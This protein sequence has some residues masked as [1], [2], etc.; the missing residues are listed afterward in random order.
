M[1]VLLDTS[2]LSNANA[3]RG[4]GTYT[5]FLLSRLLAKKNQSLELYQS[6]TLS[7]KEL[8]KIKADIVHYPYFDFFFPTLPLKLNTKTV[9]TIHDVI[10]LV[11]P[12]HYPSGKRGAI[13]LLRQK[14]ALKAVNRV[15]TDSEASKT[16]IVKYLGVEP[17][18]IKVIYLA[19]NPDLKPVSEAVLNKYRRQ[20]KLPKNYIL[21]VGDINYNKNLA[22][23]IKT[24]KYLPKEIKLVCVG[25]NFTPQEIPEWQAIESQLAL[26]NVTDRAKFLNNILGD[27]PAE[28]AAIYQGAIAYIQPSIYEGFGLPILEAMQSQTVIICGQNSSLPEVSGNFALLVDKET[29]EEFAARVEEVLT[30]N[31]TRRQRFLRA[32]SQW[33][34]KFS[35]EKTAADTI[36]LYEELE[37][38]RK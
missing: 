1:K 15:I 12:Q 29:A 8:K 24:L 33:A 26:S 21:Y 7:E 25:K 30:W 28:L 16:D 9:V 31:K 36:D 4:I 23:L 3:A 5:R 22:Q 38:S 20:L 34:K 11:F 13:N 14:I 18:K 6:G 19:A 17:G 37:R 2:P 10:P 35:W 27:D 32:A